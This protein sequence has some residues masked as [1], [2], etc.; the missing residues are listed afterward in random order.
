MKC[1]GEYNEP[2][3]IRGPT[4]KKYKLVVVAGLH[5]NLFIVSNEASWPVTT[6]IGFGL[7]VIERYPS[8]QYKGM[9]VEANQKTVRMTSCP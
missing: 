9:G 5:V 2:W 4:W 6:S 3:E 1:I 8:R 7:P